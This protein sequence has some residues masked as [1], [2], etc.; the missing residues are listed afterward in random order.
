MTG[1]RPNPKVTGEGLGWAARRRDPRHGPQACHG[2]VCQHYHPW[3]RAR[4][5]KGVCLRVDLCVS[6]SLVTHGRMD[7]PFAPKKVSVFNPTPRT[8]YLNIT[9]EN[10]VT[11]FPAEHSP[12]TP[13][14]KQG[15][16]HEQCSRT[17]TRA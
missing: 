5:S 7:P 1:R 11:V 17:R 14:R 16:A 13:V 2:G 6:C 4:A 15:R 9:R 3:L 10:V 12:T 8:T